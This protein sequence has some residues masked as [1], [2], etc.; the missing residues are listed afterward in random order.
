MRMSKCEMKK[1]FLLFM[2]VCFLFLICLQISSCASKP[3]FEG[4]S[5]LCGLVIDENNA[6]VKD[7]I[8]SCKPADVKTWGAK[9]VIS[10]VLTNESGLFVFYGLSSGQYYLSGE[11][12]NYIRLEESLY[13]FDDRTKIICLQTKGFKAAV[14]SAE[15]L[16]RLNQKK[17]AAALLGE[18]CC[19]PGSPEEKFFKD[20]IS[21]LDN[22]E[23]YE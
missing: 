17:E 21:K 9:P 19:E 22:R 2:A 23:V 15:E 16:L 4:K 3:S 20:Y 7:F 13:R 1:T 18:L 6:P 8:V 12:T 11:K 5:D 14:L 10:P